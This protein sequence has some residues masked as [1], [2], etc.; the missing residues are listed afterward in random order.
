MG[1]LFALY[2]KEYEEHLNGLSKGKTVPV[3]PAVRRES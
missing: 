1:R 3:E 2:D